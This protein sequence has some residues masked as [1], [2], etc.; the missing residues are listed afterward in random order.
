MREAQQT[1]ERTTDILDQ[2][3]RR[4]FAIQE[5]VLRQIDE[6]VRGLTWDEIAASAD[7]HQWL[8]ALDERLP[9]IDVIWLIDPQGR[10]RASSRF[11]P[12]PETSRVA[13]RDYF[14]ALRERDEGTY[15]GEPQRGRTATNRVF[16]NIARRRSAEGGTFD[17]VILTS[18][19]PVYFANDFKA[20]A[21]DPGDS[22][23]LIREDGAALARGPEPLSGPLRL[24]PTSG[25]LTNLHQGER[26]SFRVHSQIDGVERLYAFRKLPGYPAYVLYGRSMQAVRAGWYRDLWLYG[27]LAAAAAA[28]LFFIVQV[29]ARRTREQQRA[30]ERLRESEARYHALFH[31]SPLGLLLTQVRQDGTLAFEEM[32]DA[33][34]QI[35]GHTREEVLGK[36][37]IQAFPGSMGGLIE[38]RYRQSIATKQPIE[39]EVASEGPNGRFVRRAVVRPILDGS[40][41]VAKLLGTSIDITKARLLEEQLQ[42]SQKME[43]L[44]GLVSGVAHDFNNLLTVVMGNLDLLRRATEERRP[45]LIENAIQ[46]VERGRRLTS[47]LLAFGRKQTLTPEVVDLTRL[48]ASTQDMIAQSLRGDIEVKLDLAADL[49]PVRVD[50]SQLQVALINLAV[51]ARDAMPKGGTFTVA[52]ENRVSHGQGTSETVALTVSDTGSGMP[53]EVLARAFEPFFTTKDVGRGTGLGLAQVYGFAQQSGGS[54]DIGSEVGRGTTVTLYLPRATGEEVTLP[55]E[56][57]P[58]PVGRAAVERRVLLVEDN[59]EVAEVGRLILAERGHHVTVAANVSQALDRLQGEAFDIVVSDLV[60]PGEK[61]GL[62]L[63]RIVARRWPNIPIVLMTGYSEAAGQAVTEGFALLRKPYEPADL[64]DAVESATAAK[65]IPLSGSRR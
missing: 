4:V 44:S 17:G 23:S 14:R 59:N 34:A 45:R 53:R 6:R 15:F 47:Q 36:S 48:V 58:P 12:A 25:L 41:R 31:E 57:A 19:D 8:V 56:A 55:A 61:N 22:L 40:G 33:L 18:L 52:A 20:L 38:E 21:L 30:L 29:A 9:Q 65:V 11:F 26:G 24:A 13:D 3:A 2:Q 16:M 64:I 42:R 50:P 39:Y 54:V 7:L 32:N 10:G 27:V 51:N 46:A 60:M 63:A 43:A 5:L 1:V 37:P 62:G 35:T 28:S 49:W